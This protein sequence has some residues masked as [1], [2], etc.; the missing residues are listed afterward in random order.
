MTAI[1]CGVLDVIYHF[2]FAPYDGPLW[3]LFAIFIL[4]LFAPIA[5][6]AKKHKMMKAAL[7]IVGIII[8]VVM[9]SF[10]VLKR[11][12]LSEDTHF[13]MWVNRL[14]RY[15]PCYEIGS[16]IGIVVHD[17]VSTDTISIQ[18]RTGMAVF[19][20]LTGLMWIMNPNIHNLYKQM[21]I[22]VTPMLAWLMTSENKF[23]KYNNRVVRNGFLIYATHFMVIFVFREVSK[24]IIPTTGETASFL[25]WIT[26]PIICVV[27]T[28]FWCALFD[29]LL[30]KTKLEKIESM[31]TGSRT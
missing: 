26:E 5:L 28:Y 3:Y 17:E 1:L 31:L 8:P 14:F 9:F 27:L 11:C 13:I 4:T 7:I 20:G 30:R 23:G 22:M 24:R 6:F 21:I 25:V 18:Y 29:L 15:L 12:G 19:I 16:I 2:T 10:D